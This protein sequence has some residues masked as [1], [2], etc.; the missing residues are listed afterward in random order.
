MPKV[1]NKYK[2]PPKGAVYIGRGSI[3]GNPF[4]ITATQDRNK[5]CN[6]Y[7]DYVEADPVKKALFIKNLQ[8]K[9]LVCFCSPAEVS[10]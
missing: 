8:G 10:W 7:E 1:Y 4:P 5:V 2:N 6:M 9:D 3:Y